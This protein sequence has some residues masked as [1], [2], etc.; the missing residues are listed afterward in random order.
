MFGKAIAVRQHPCTL[1]LIY[2]LT[3]PQ[4][5]LVIKF[6]VTDIKICASGLPQYFQILDVL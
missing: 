2:S 6:G 5:A 1:C 4:A 3:K